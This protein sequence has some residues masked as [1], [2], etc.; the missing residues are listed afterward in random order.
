MAVTKSESSADENFVTNMKAAREALGWTQARL[1]EELNKA[2]VD[3]ISQSAVSRIEKGERDVRLNE[4]RAIAKAFG[5]SLDSFSGPPEAFKDVLAWNEVRG[6]FTTHWKMA[7]RMVKQYEDARTAFLEY[8][9][10]G[11]VT[12]S[13]RAQREFEEMADYQLEFSTRRSRDP[14]AEPRSENPPF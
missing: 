4:A 12:L 6:R 10:A 8:L 7:Q 1:A 5:A 2:G 13:A 3:S 14:W 11:H 9:N